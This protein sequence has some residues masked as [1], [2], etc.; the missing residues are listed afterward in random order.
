MAV[1]LVALAGCGET[2]WLTP[3]VADDT[4]SLVVAIERAG[5]V[6]LFAV[7]SQ[8]DFQVDVGLDTEFAVTVLAYG[9]PLT[10]LGLNPGPLELVA[11]GESGGQLPTPQQVYV[12]DVGRGGSFAGWEV[13]GALPPTIA[14]VRFRTTSVERCLIA[15]GCFPDRGGSS[16]TPLCVSP[17]PSPPRDPMP[18]VAPNLR[19]PAAPAGWIRTSSAG[20]SWDRPGVEGPCPASEF[21]TP[22]A[23]DCAPIDTCVDT[24]FR[25][26]GLRARYV[27]PNAPAGGDGREAAPYRTLAEAYAAGATEIALARGTHGVRAWPAYP[28]R[29]VGVCA[30]ETTLAVAS[31]AQLDHD[32]ELSHLTVRQSLRLQLAAALTANA[33]MLAS[34]V[35]IEA[36][37]R[38]AARRLHA[39]ARIDVLEQGELQGEDLFFSGENGA[40][41]AGL[42]NLRD[43]HFDTAYAAFVVAPTGRAT[44][45]QSALRARDGTVV[46]S[47][48]ELNLTAVEIRATAGRKSGLHSLLGSRLAAS[49]LTILESGAQALLV[50][51][52][53][54]VEH[55][56]IIPSSGGRS[57]QGRG[58][59]VASGGRLVGR[60]VEIAGARGV[61]AHVSGPRTELVLEDARIVDT[62]PDRGLEFGTAV[63]VEESGTATLRRVEVLRSRNVGIDVTGR[64]TEAEI[65]DLLI[66]GVAPEALTGHDGWGLRAEKNSKTVLRRAIIRNSTAIGL[67]VQDL[68]FLEGEEVVIENTRA[69]EQ[70]S[71]SNCSFGPAGGL[72]AELNSQAS[73]RNFVLRNNIAY[74]ASITIDAQLDLRDGLIDTHQVGVVIAVSDYPLPRLFE[75]V[76]IMNSLTS[77]ERFNQ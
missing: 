32:V 57:G 40:S 69:T 22:A 29:L 63:R 17:C 68:A 62:Q 58:L 43:A 9:R 67:L 54:E 10:E 46:R 70:C 27:D 38:L 1:L 44:L 59:Q 21:R 8:E 48:G 45:S 5:R 35:R 26:A 23:P 19:R 39:T 76:E 13:A 51:G 73:L 36:G 31:T 56:V 33:V 53:A 20:L 12:A 18:P 75:R 14:A 65:E 25:P 11:P 28:V 64:D 24:N 74:G 52:F 71:R 34:P 72:R 61:G 37:G 16:G 4:A 47:S 6:R 66:D 30:G 77:V 50:Q 55:L 49:N 41:V 7:D 2:L 3:P 60:H 15:G 42:A